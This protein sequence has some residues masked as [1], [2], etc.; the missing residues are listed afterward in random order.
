MTTTDDALMVTQ[1][2]VARLIGGCTKTVQRLAKSD[3]TFPPGINLLGSRN[4]LRYLKSDV[5]A[6][7]EA[8]AEAARADRVRAAERRAAS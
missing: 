3:P 8:R 1:A 7:C 6:W 5:V 4:G 2:D